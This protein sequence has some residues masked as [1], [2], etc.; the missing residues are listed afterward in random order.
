LVNVPPPPADPLPVTIAASIV[1]P[2]ELDTVRPFQMFPNPPKLSASSLLITACAS[3]EIPK[4][5][6]T[7]AAGTP[8]RKVI[9]VRF[10]QLQKAYF[11]MLVTLSP[12]VTL[13]RLLQP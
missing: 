13:V 1:L 2:I 9:F 3:S 8:P 10:Q 5:A 7:P 4:K 6:L 11:P 12:I